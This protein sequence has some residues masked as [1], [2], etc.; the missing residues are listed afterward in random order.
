MTRS[1]A[2]CF[3]LLFGGPAIQ[4]AKK[5]KHVQLSL[6]ALEERLAPA[7]FHVTNIDDS[8]PGSFRQAILDSNATKGPNSIVFQTPGGGFEAIHLDSKLPTITETVSIDATTEPAYQ[9]SGVPVITLDGKDAGRDAN[10]LS[11]TAPD[12]NIKGL[13]IINFASGAGIEIEKGGG[14][15]IGNCYIG[16]DQ[17]GAAGANGTGILIEDSNN[18]TIG[19][20]SIGVGTRFMPRNLI[21][22]NNGFGIQIQGTSSNNK[23]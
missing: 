5:K 12:C 20:L 16:V 21:S 17:S 7:T 22:S 23:Y 15:V 19:G 3:R 11:I 6:E 8:G 4:R 14:T 18:N 9:G 10:G 13:S 1:L 2:S